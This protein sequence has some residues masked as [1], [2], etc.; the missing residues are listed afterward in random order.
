[1]DNNI[2]RGL[3]VTGTD[4]GVGKTVV[5][6]ALAAALRRRGVDVGVMKPVQTGAVRASDGLIALDAR[7]LA[8]VAEVDDPPDLVCP[9]LLEAPLAPSVAAELE[10]RDIHPAEILAAYRELQKRHEAVMVEGAGGICV[11]ITGTYLMSDLAREMELPLL[12]VAR[13]SL[14]TINHTVLT[15]HFARAAGLEVLGVAIN[16]YPADPGLAE[17][18]SPAVIEKLAGVPVLGFVAHDP[19]VDVDTGKAGETVT[20]MEGSALLERLL[21]LLRD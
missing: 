10:R 17:R 20:R 2:R 21:A 8:A 6:A 16:N 13:P 14:G 7:F 12:V 15:V 9:V 19:K 4:T 3:F 11:P 1:V 5:T 18:T